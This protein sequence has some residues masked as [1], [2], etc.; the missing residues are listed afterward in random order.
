MGGL[1]EWVARATAAGG[2]RRVRAPV[3]GPPGPSQLSSP[4]TDCAGGVLQRR[5]RHLPVAGGPLLGRAETHRRGAPCCL[6]GAGDS[7][8]TSLLPSGRKPGNSS[9]EAP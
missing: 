8:K 2:G 6:G 4:D 9:S 1:V 3:P 7:R 5:A